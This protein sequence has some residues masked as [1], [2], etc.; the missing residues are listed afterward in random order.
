MMAQHPA[1]LSAFE[2][3]KLRDLS[4][5]FVVDPHGQR[6]RWQNTIENERGGLFDRAENSGIK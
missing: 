2:M 4:H 3:E 6:R 1:G 5:N